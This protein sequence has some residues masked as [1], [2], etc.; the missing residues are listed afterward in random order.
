MGCRLSH[1]GP[2]AMRAAVGVGKLN[3]V[4]VEERRIGVNLEAS[5]GL[6]AAR[7]TLE[8]VAVEALGCLLD[9]FG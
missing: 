3:L 6:G 8:V 1:S 4:A 7:A 2:L 9:R 5:E